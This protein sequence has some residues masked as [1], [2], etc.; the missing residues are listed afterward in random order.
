[1]QRHGWTLLFHDCVI[2]Q[3]Q[4]LYTA[5][6]RAE[7]ND[8]IGFASNA[9]VKLFR[10]LSQLVL[11]VVPG[12]PARDEYRQGNTLGPEYRHW[13]RAKIGRRFRLF[14]RYDSRAKVIVYAW[15]NDEQTL[16]ASGSKSDPY[17]VFE[18]ML[19]RGN[20]PDDWDALVTASRQ[21]WSKLE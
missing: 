6:Q 3:L 2:E 5:A 21:N 4:R 18:K 14:F 1:M 12:E 13:R 7:Q 8:P 11:E 16:R 17:A 19:G 20:P 9:N 10:A 15:V